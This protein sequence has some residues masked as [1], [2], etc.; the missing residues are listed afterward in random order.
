MGHYGFHCQGETGDPNFNPQSVRDAIVHEHEFYKHEK[1]NYK[2]DQNIIGSISFAVFILTM[3]IAGPMF[4]SIL[5]FSLVYFHS[6]AAH[7]IMHHRKKK[8]LMA[9]LKSRR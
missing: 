9:R 6:M 7:E 8:K 1:I 4:E 3:L 2:K 5:V